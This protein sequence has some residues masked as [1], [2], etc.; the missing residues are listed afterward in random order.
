MGIF[1]MSAPSEER[2]KE[3]ALLWKRS[4]S[5]QHASMDWKALNKL[6]A[7]SEAEEIRFNEMD[8]EK[9]KYDWKELNQTD[10]L[11]H[12]IKPFIPKTKKDL[13]LPDDQQRERKQVDFADMAT[14]EDVNEA[15]YG[16]RKVRLE[17]D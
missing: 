13:I 16:K 5:V 7:R 6:I 8:T 2:R 11:P 15:I 12:F 1:D 10:E 14:E 17:S 4:N 3:Q 9:E